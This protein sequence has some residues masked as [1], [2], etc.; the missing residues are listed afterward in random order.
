VKKYQFKLQKVLDLRKIRERQV[1]RELGE[2]LRSLNEC[3]QQ[4]QERLLLKGRFAERF[5]EVDRDG[6]L[7]PFEFRRYQGFLMNLSRDAQLHR[8]KKE[9]QSEKVDEV[10]VR[11][12]AAMGKT[13]AFEKLEE[14][15]REGYCRERQ[16]EELKTMSE[17][18]LQRFRR[19]SERGQAMVLLMAIGAVSFLLSLLT[20]ALLFAV[21]SLTPHRLAVMGQIMRYR[22]ENW[23]EAVKVVGDDEPYLLARSKYDEM[24]S[25]AEK[26]RLHELGQ[27]DDS[28]PL[29]KDVLD[30]R[31]E[32]L[33][34]MESSLERMHR[35]TLEEKRSLEQ[36]ER[37]LLEKNAELKMRSDRLGEQVAGRK[38]AKDDEAEQGILE[39][40]KAMDPDAVV[41]VLT[42][43][44]EYGDADSEEQQQATV[45]K[46]T[47]YLS[48][49]EPRRRAGILE[50]L[51]PRWAKEVIDHMQSGSSL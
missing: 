43:E 17:V 10:R 29:T 1:Q 12:R 49:M 22:G 44:R 6:R 41:K 16:Q 51:S 15:A 3:E 32:M 11:L 21:G 37:L 5:R 35:E 13:Q 38:K 30:Q 27:L 28:I 19:S 33:A 26:W 8:E 23:Q 9:Q 14:V 7:D 31:R 34:M 40:F 24:Q 42:A 50:A 45:A 2:E 18:A 46:I 25:D 20:I 36:R 4:L 48:K 47:K 39:A